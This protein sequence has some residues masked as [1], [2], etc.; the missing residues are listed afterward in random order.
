MINVDAPTRCTEP[1]IQRMPA[2]SEPWR[3]PWCTRSA[4][5]QAGVW[6]QDDGGDRGRAFWDACPF[7][8]INSGSHAR[9]G[10]YGLDGLPAFDCATQ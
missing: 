4:A 3:T 1:P 6:R 8:R 5:R 7:D 10:A 2:I 9:W